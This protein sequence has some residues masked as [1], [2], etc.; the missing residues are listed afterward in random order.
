[1][2]DGQRALRE[3][4]DAAL[5]GVPP[6]V[7]VLLEEGMRQG[8]RAIRRR[9]FAHIATASATFAV[10][11]GL[12][13]TAVPQSI[14]DRAESR[15]AATDAAVAPTRSVPLT[16]Q[17]ALQTLLDLLPPNTETS[18]YSGEGFDRQ[19]RQA[20]PYTASH[21]HL[22]VGDSAGDADLD[23]AISTTTTD[24][25]RMPGTYRSCPLPAS[26]HT[27]HCR[28]TTLEDGSDLLVFK[29]DSSG[30]SRKRV[31]SWGATLERADGLRISLL[32][33]KMPQPG[34]T[35]GATPPL[36]L[37]QLS[38]IITND[39]WQRTVDKTYATRAEG[40]F[41]LDHAGS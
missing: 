4:L 11:G 1:M 39:R 19:W 20:E 2:T 16:P 6:N 7:P 9:R 33:R 23:L 10:V 12:L 3:V 27:V 26:W 28:T 29:A 32:E 17:A 40:L 21:V 34:G 31:V 5:D 25:S 15:P 22:V 36:S 14:G 37:D 30:G 13:V 38:A 8:D 35:A 24:P 18:G 41:E